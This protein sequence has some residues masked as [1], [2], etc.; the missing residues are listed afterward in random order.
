MVGSLVGVADRTA[1]ER[2]VYLGAI[3]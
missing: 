2:D 1:P 3:A